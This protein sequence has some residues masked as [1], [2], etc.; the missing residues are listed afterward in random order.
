[1]PTYTSYD[2]VGKKEDVSDIITNISPTK[3]PFQAMIGT[4]KVE[5]TLFQWQ[6]DSLA[7]VAAN[8]Q[9]EGFTAVDGTQTPTVM[10]QNVTQILSKVI[11]ISDTNDAVSKYGRARESAYQM[12]KVAAEAK[13]DLENALIGVNQ[14]AVV[15]TNVVARQMA[16]VRAQVNAGM[17]TANAGAAY[18]EANFL[19]VLQNCYAAGTD[20][21]VAMCS[22]TDS[23]VI[24]DFARASGR[25][26]EIVTG[27]QDRTIVNAVDLYV[28][29]FGQVKV[30]LNRFIRAQDTLIFEPDMWKLCVL[31]PWTRQTLAKTGDNTLMMLVGEYSL[32]HKNWGASGIVAHA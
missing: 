14:A 1:M 19:T 21:S 25:L 17:V 5:N 11:R 26:R 27:Q 22:P 20:P 10:R 13:R 8:A 16:S 15:G 18:T 31:R 12:S 2:A 9:V 32:K 3:T 4:E 30:I 24:A 23:L 7:A 28:S 29:P 6:E